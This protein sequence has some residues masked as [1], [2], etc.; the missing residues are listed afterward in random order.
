MRLLI[1]EEELEWDEAWQICRQTFAY[2]NH[3][4]LPEALERWSVELLNNLLPRHMELI[5]QINDRFLQQVRHKNPR[6]P[7]LLSRVSMIEEGWEKQ[8]RMPFLSIVGSHT[9][10]GVAALHTELLKETI[11]RD[12][13]NLFPERF[14]NKT[15]G[16][17]PR[18]WLRCANPELAELI[19]DHIGSDWI[20]DLDKLENLL[21]LASTESFQH[22]WQEVKKLKKQQLCDWILATH[23]V[24]LAVDSLFDVQVK[25]IHEYKR[26]LLNI[27]H[28]VHLYD[29]LRNNPKM[30][31]PKRTFL[32]GGKAAPGYYMAKQIIRL[33]ND[34]AAKVNKDVE[35]DDRLRVLFVTNYGVSNSEKIIAASEVSEHISTAGTEASGTSNMKFSLNGCILLGTHDGATI[36]IGEEVG[37]ENIFTFGMKANDVQQLRATGYDPQQIYNENPRVKNVLDLVGSGFFNPQEPQRYRDLIDS[38]IYN[39]HYLLLADFDAYTA[40]QELVGKTYQDV[41]TWTQ[42]S[43]ANTAKVGKFSSDRTI[44]EYATQIWNV[45]PLLHGR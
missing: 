41:P 24:E 3:T 25:R 11:F 36:E 27:L 1:D 7:G 19:S 34:V 38:L 16:I 5:Y 40:C 23:K 6:D 35:I 22:Q 8:V 29:Q 44:R 13:Y 43:I 15:N 31:V 20:T 9:T 37:S 10:N 12:F 39:D 28:V 14:Q 26:Q 21:D 42:M 30:N 4:V 2:T 33:I 32:F 18:L 17:T 45:H